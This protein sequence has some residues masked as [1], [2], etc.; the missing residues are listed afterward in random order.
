VTRRSKLPSAATR[1][2]SYHVLFDIEW[3][4]RKPPFPRVTTSSRP[5]GDHAG[6]RYSPA[7]FVRRTGSPPPARTFHNAPSF[8]SSKV[9]NATHWPSGDHAG[10]SSTAVNEAGVNRF[11]MPLG[12]SAIHSFPAPSNVARPTIAAR[13]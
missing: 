7:T 1:R 4:R 2:S 3:S 9:V 10:E 11:G 12:T 6:W 13:R 8:S 5:S